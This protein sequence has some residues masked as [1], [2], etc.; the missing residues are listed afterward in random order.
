MGAFA[1][2][3]P[4]Y[5]VAV[6]L[7]TAGLPARLAAGVVDAHGDTSAAKLADD[8]WLLLDLPEVKPAHADTLARSMLGGGARR[9]DVRRGR[10]LVR[11]L[12]MRAAR[13]G[14]TAM[15]LNTVHAALEGFDAGDPA[16]AVSAAI[17]DGRVV[18]SD[19]DDPPLLALTRYAMAEESV[20]EGLARL[21]A[22]AKPLCE[23]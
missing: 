1:E 19:D 23:P 2:A 5:D 3:R 16:V 4:A 22:T 9:D 15:P 11:H 6:H 7:V 17:D 20:A 12:L 8:P 13:D 10:A 18:F 21:A 14:H